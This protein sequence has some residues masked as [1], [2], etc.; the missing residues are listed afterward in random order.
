MA[1][2]STEALK[3]R[4][5]AAEQVRRRWD[6]V[7]DDCYDLAMP[8][9][10]L[11]FG[12]TRGQQHTDR[13][14]DST[15]IMATSQ[16]VSRLQ[17]DLTPPFRRWAKLQPGPM[18]PDEHKEEIRRELQEIE[19]IA[20]PL[21]HASNLDTALGEG[22]FDLAI[23]TMCLLPQPGPPDQPLRFIAAPLAQCYLERGPDG[24][25][26]G[27]VRQFSLRL[28]EI[29]RKWPDAK[30]PDSMKE[31]A[32]ADGTAEFAVQEFS[33]KDRVPGSMVAYYDVLVTGESRSGNLERIVER[34]YP[35]GFPWI[36]PRWLV[37]A[38]EVYGRGPLMEALP[39]IRV[40]N[41]LAEFELRNAAL[42]VQGVYIGIADEIPE[43][44]DFA[45]GAVIPVE[46]IGTGTSGASL[47][48]LERAG[49]LQFHQLVSERLQLRIRKALFDEDLPAEAGPV[50]SATEIIQRI[51]QLQQRIGGPFAR[52]HSELIVPLFQRVMDILSER[53]MI[54]FPV[55]IDS[56]TVQVNV[57]SPLARE[58]NIS[59]LD[60]LMQWI[61]L[62]QAIQPQL[63]LLGAKVEDMPQ[64]MGEKLG[65]DQDLIRDE[66]EIEQG[67]QM[68]AT[69][70]GAQAGQAV[71][72][73][74]DQ[75]QGT[76]APE[77]A[78]AA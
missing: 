62:M 24:S 36:T 2:E 54:R 68:I 56:L 23:G 33:Y 42:A 1:R 59:D 37:V 39:D 17:G 40:M 12:H 41:K 11:M 32:G 3:R 34:D 70:I 46:R 10:Q 51:K 15:A 69:L 16:F 28:D 38:G 27:L 53:G 52:I 76:G 13:S 48:P 75:G 44:I 61:Q 50:R 9:R 26:D 78:Q 21:M 77:V 6:N 63:P 5:G 66:S 49:D 57:T 31:R 4:I 30:I 25:V 8:Q 72:D 65:V 45:P 71:S 29:Q 67:K 43:T 55:R 58:E 14:Y 60:A 47:Q 73:P 19:N 7:L 74:G 22:Y 18:V 64:W 35:R 20:W